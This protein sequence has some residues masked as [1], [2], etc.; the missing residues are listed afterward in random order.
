MSRFA[1]PLYLGSPPK[2][3]SVR[4]TA[5]AAVLIHGQNLRY[6]QQIQQRCLTTTVYRGSRGGTTLFP[7]HHFD[8]RYLACYLAA[9]VGAAHSSFSYYCWLQREENEAGKEVASRGRIRSSN[10]EH[11]QVLATSPPDSTSDVLVSSTTGD[12]YVMVVADDNESSSRFWH[13]SGRAVR[14]VWRL[15]KLAVV[16]TPLV[17]LYPVVRL[18]TFISTSTSSDST[19][20]S[21]SVHRELERD[22][23]EILLAETDSDDP[24]NS[25]LWN[26]YL[27]QCLHAV[28]SSGAAMIK[29][30]Q[31]AGG[32]PDLFGHEF[33]GVFSR[34]QDNARPHGF[35]HTEKA[36]TA[37]YGE[38]WSSKIELREILGSGCIGQVYHGRI[39]TKGSD[40]G[41]GRQVAVKVLHPGVEADIDADLDLMRAAV[42]VVQYL[43]PIGVGANLKWLNMGGIVEEFAGLLRKQLDLRQ[44][45]AN[46]VQFNK[47]FAS[48]AAVEFPEIVEEFA[49]SQHVLVETYCNGIPVLQ[50]ARQHQDDSEQL[51]NLCLTA[52]RAVCKMIFLDN[53]MHGDLHPGM[54][55]G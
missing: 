52:I 44:E 26:W 13:L 30:G 10:S 1:R 17:A 35:S 24:N 50:Y 41:S 2:T 12:D 7:H 32:R 27:R 14:M 33:C 29:L 16:W 37:A 19:L 23:H 40:A 48:D 21:A 43:E 22:A 46:L 47:N 8:A 53:F 5:A 51:H 38:D 9:A 25:A 28:E 4:M 45:A 18:G 6:R 42:R 31:W 34:L 15:M 20:S 54:L 39:L 36:M 55:V 49:P 11:Q 3:L